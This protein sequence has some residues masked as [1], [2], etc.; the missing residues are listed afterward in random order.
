MSAETMMPPSSRFR[1]WQM[2]YTGNAFLDKA[3][4][5][6]KDFVAIEGNLSLSPGKDRVQ[7]LAQLDISA[8]AADRLVAARIDDV[9]KLINLSA[10]AELPGFS[11]EELKELREK[12]THWEKNFAVDLW[13]ISLRVWSLKKDIDYADFIKEVQACVDPIIAEANAQ[14]ALETDSISASYTGMVPVV[15]KTQHELYRGLVYSF[16]ASFF[17]IGIAMCVVLRSPIAGFLAM[18]PNLFPIFIVFGFMGQFGVLIDIGTMMTA[19]VAL[20]IAT[21]DT[22]HFLTWFRDGIDKGMSRAE[23]TQYAYSRCA[24][25]M[26]QTTLIAGF[27]LAAFALSTFTPT[28]M[29]GT[30]ML[31][32]LMTAMLGNL[33]FLAALLN[34]P[35]GRYFEPFGK[36]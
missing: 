34:T 5:E 6:L 15:Y 36:R 3:R 19:S 16:I 17:M 18:I 12:A 13:R 1:G 24:S 23:A 21:D 25:A 33:I 29:F 7:N 32:I 10:D 11:H 28:Q 31:A 4:G 30:M 20:G 9:K 2:R 14:L 26:F 8:D 35:I 22:I 27:G